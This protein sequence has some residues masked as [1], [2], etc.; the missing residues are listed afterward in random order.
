[1]HTVTLLQVKDLLAREVALR[2]SVGNLRQEKQGLYNQLQRAMQTA[3]LH[4]LGQGA[5]RIG[6]EESAVCLSG[7]EDLGREYCSPYG[8]E[9]VH[10]HDFPGGSH[11]DA[12]E[13]RVFMTCGEHDTM[14]VVKS[15]STTMLAYQNTPAESKK[16]TFVFRS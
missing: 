7:A 13:V 6:P 16:V 15:H 5:A 4:Y 10:K 8:H 3:D 12:Q 9:I 2:E 11:D 14:T 1:M